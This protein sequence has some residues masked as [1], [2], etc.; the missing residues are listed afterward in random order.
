MNR[1]IKRDLQS[2][3]ESPVCGK[4]NIKYHVACKAKPYIEKYC[5]ENK[6]EG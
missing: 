1:D 3:R 4:E 5:A 6:I 2:S